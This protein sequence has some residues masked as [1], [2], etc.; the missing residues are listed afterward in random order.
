MTTASSESAF[1]TLGRVAW[2]GLAL[3]L[4]LAAACAGA[5]PRPGGPAP[6]DPLLGG[7]ARDAYAT[8]EAHRAR[9]KRYYE[10]QRFE[11]AIAEF[12]AGYEAA[13]WPVFLFNLA[14]ARKQLGDC[15]AVQAYRRFLVELEQ[16]A[17]ADPARVAAEPGAPVARRN[18]AQLEPS[19][20]TAM[21][22]PTRPRPRRWHERREIALAMASGV[23][24]AAA[25]GGLMAWGEREARAA[26]RMAARPAGLDAVDDRVTR[27]QRL[28]V[29]GGAALALGLG[30]AVAA[31]LYHRARPTFVDEITVEVGGGHATAWLGGR[32]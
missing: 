7:D 8:A 18:L 21:A 24:V 9:G 32:F 17:P 30:G 6:A 16:R 25:G 28:R 5:T 3:S 14:Q 11:Q 26:A 22:L 10:T 1:R 31:Y 15:R 27:A 19:C 2:F 29:A 20:A 23:V 13:P 4:L 12:Q